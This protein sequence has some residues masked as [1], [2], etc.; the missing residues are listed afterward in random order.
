VYDNARLGQASM[1]AAISSAGAASASIQGRSLGRNTVG[2]VVAHTRECWQRL[3]SQW[4]VNP[5]V[6]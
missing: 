6:G 1:A 5:V 2:S 3:E 4:T